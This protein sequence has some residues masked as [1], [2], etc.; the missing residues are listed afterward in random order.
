MS[1]HASSQAKSILLIVPPLTNNH[2]FPELGVPQLTAFLKAHGHT[3]RQLDLNAVMLG[4]WLLE[5]TPMAT[6]VAGLSPE[7]TA[8]VA[9]LPAFLAAQRAKI[10]NVLGMEQP[11]TQGSKTG[12]IDDLV[13]R[14]LDQREILQPTLRADILASDKVPTSNAAEALHRLRQGCSDRLL[15]T[16]W[17]DV[18]R[19]DMDGD[20]TSAAAIEAATQHNPKILQEFLAA[21]LDPALTPDVG[22]VGLSIHGTAQVTTALRIARHVRTRLPSARILIGGPWCTAAAGLLESQPWVFDYVDGVVLGEGE[23]AILKAAEALAKG[24]D[25]MD[26]PG[27]MRYIDSQVVTSAPAA[28]LPLEA[29]PGPCFDGYPMEAFTAPVVPFRTIRGCYWS[30]CVF[31]YHVLAGATPAKLNGL[32]Q[33]TVSNLIET[34]GDATSRYGTRGLA[35]ADHA[36]PPEYLRTVAAALKSNGLEVE[37]EA[38]VRF[39]D[40]FNANL[41]REIAAA[42]CSRLNFGLESSQAASLRHIRKGIRLDL[43]LRCLEE[44]TAAGIEA[45]VFV[46]HYPGQTIDAFEETL[47]FVEE[48]SDIIGWFSAQRFQ[49]GRQSHAFMNPDSLGIRLPARAYEDFSVFD[50]PFEADGWSTDA[51]FRQ[52][53]EKHFLR[54]LGRKAM[55]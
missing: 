30:R 8:H 26:L 55:A 37:W 48:H 20:D 18:L 17:A 42:G 15:W 43:A 51:E 38:L 41:F 3:V 46:L 47:R 36:T 34:V 50:L 12:R 40:G 1:S 29:L 14:Y 21:H 27:T 32:S 45:S 39:D 31:C 35:L 28:P 5:P 54:F 53:T 49:L 10:A 33:T 9:A 22:L 11:K 2:V 6:A 13:R 4:S 19:R 44:A 16:L 25:P 7:A 52:V 23:A 24:L